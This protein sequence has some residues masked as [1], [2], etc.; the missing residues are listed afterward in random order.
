[1]KL[2]PAPIRTLPYPSRAVQRILT[3][4]ARRLDKLLRMMVS[5]MPRR[6]PPSPMD[7]IRI[8]EAETAITEALHARDVD[9][10]GGVDV[11]AR[12]LE[13]AGRIRA[14]VASEPEVGAVRFDG[15]YKFTF[16]GCPRGGVAKACVCDGACWRKEGR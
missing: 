13:E 16:V 12:R 10:A 4:Q 14:R 15:A 5:P 7:S 1:V 11:L 3:E 2:P 9:V 6:P 8:R